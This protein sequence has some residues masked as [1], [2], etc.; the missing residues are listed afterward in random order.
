VCCNHANGCTLSRITAEQCSAFP[1]KVE[2]ERCFPIETDWVG[3]PTDAISGKSEGI[4]EKSHECKPGTTLKYMR[5]FEKDALKSGAIKAMRF[6]CSDDYTHEPEFG[7]KKPNGP[8]KRT[9]NNEDVYVANDN[10]VWTSLNWGGRV[11][12]GIGSGNH[13]VGNREEPQMLWCEKGIKGAK[14]KASNGDDGA[15]HAIKLTCW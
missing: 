7:D 11:L 9:Y 5:V 2:G 6:Y 10:S 3:F 12:R 15:I 14:V 4:S 8:L 13:W 1:G